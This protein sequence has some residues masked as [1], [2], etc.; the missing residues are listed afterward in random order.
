MS[1]IPA[2]A[3]VN[4]L[5]GVLNAGG[6]ALEL[7]G[8]VLTQNTRVPIG[9]VESFPNATAVSNFFGASSH[10]AAIANVYFGGYSTA[11]AFPAAILFT[12]FPAGGVSAYLQSGDVAALG[13]SA[14][15]ALSGSLT[16]TIDG[17][18]FAD[19]SLNL[20][21]ATSFSAAA[22][23]I[24]TG[25]NNTLPSAA[26]VTGSI[27]AE[28]ASV[29]ASIAGYVMTVTGMTS[30]TLVPGAAISGT[31]VTSGTVI[32]SQLSG[33]PGG[34]GTYAVSKSQ[35]VASETISASYGLLTVSAMGSGTLSVGQTLS[36]TGV[37]AGTQI[38][39]LGTGTGLTGTYYVN[40]SQ[41]VASETIT[42]TATALSVSF[43]SVSG[44]F[45]IT[46]GTIGAQSTAAFATGTL[47]ASLLL[48]SATG[49]ILSQGS[50]A[51][52]PGTFMNGVI[53]QTQNWATFMTAFDPDGGSGNAQK[54]LFS[55]W[56]NSTD[57]QFA[58][59]CWDTDITPTESS[60]AS[61]SLGQILKANN[62]SG[63]ILTYEPSDLYHAAFVCGMIASI[64]FSAQNGRITLFGKT[65]SGLVAGVTNATVAAN[66]L[67][68][69]Y[70]FV[71]AYATAN[72][73]FVIYNNGSISGPFKW[74]NTYV[75][76]IWLNSQCQLALMDL[77]TAINSV[78][79]NA[80][81]AQLI[82]SAL[83]QP[84]KQGVTFGAIRAGVVLSSTQIAN[85]NNAA[86]FDVATTLQNIG[87][88][89]LIKP[90]S[91]QV[92][93]ARGP[94]AI[95]LWYCDGGDVQTITLSSI[96]VQ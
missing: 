43:D 28:T 44:S 25:L 18:T 54:Q 90:A 46:S 36:G 16:V 8:L 64:D 72:Q 41:T 84:I 70:S 67:A 60:N 89:L 55:A 33:T 78:P 5:P 2:S 94:W 75:N 31:G 22:A 96:E 69:G 77:F 23:L 24:Q 30:G 65:Q 91:P 26:S 57:D 59:S 80:A 47:A 63:T 3:L 38:T 76:Q 10:E 40:P 39:A 51:E 14:I 45:F 34:I 66:L 56:T 79:F 61:S 17:Y 6:N 20:A 21:P 42:A 53:Q 85:V 87:W 4:V 19:A 11:T 37:T 12:Q 27:A 62:S 15:Q 88:Y 83:L 32:N 13:L 48:T 52:L 7:L 74:A 49:G 81:G 95:T 92:R 86:G 9:T 1:T 93:A 71:G 35:I 73:Q 82:R 58:Y 68:N 29:T 50:A